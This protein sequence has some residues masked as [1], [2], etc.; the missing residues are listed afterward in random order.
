MTTDVSAQPNL[1]STRS[2]SVAENPAITLLG[3]WAHPDD[4]SYLSS[5]LMSRV[6]SA[7]GRGPVNLIVRHEYRGT[8]VPLDMS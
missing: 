1:I 3:V 7:G 6:A 8:D 4:E 2:R 5:I